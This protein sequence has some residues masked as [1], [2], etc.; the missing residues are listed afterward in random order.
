MSPDELKAH[1]DTLGWSS[2]HLARVLGIPQGTP[3]NW[4]M[5]RYAVPPYVAAWLERWVKTCEQ[6][7]QRDPPPW[8]GNLPS[9]EAADAR[10]MELNRRKPWQRQRHKRL[11]EQ[12]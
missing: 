4:T 8:K 3:A 6:A 1:L 10:R 7:M 11:L 2:R 9:W 12:E 5:G